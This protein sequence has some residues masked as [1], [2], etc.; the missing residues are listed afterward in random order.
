MKKMKFSKFLLLL[1]FASLCF[2][3]GFAA[4]PR[5]TPEEIDTARAEAQRCGYLIR[6]ANPSQVST[7]YQMHRSCAPVHVYAS[8]A[9]QESAREKYAEI[10]EERKR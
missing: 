4:G 6:G 10:W 7:L 5:A 1:L 9:A 2:A 3:A 8:K